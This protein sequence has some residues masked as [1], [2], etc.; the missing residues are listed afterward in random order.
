MI[1]RIRRTFSQNNAESGMSV[2][3]LLVTMIL[4]GMILLMAS[5]MYI[6]VV[7]TTDDSKS[8]N[9]GTRVAS[10]AMNELNRVV[11]FAVNSP[12]SGA[13]PLPA[14]SS[15]KASELVVYSLVDVDG[16]ASTAERPLKPVMVKIGLESDGNVFE[17]RWNPTASGQFWSF[18]GVSS[19]ANNTA[20]SSRVLGGKF[21]ATGT[22]TSLFRYFTDDCSVPNPPSMSIIDHLVQHCTE[23][24]PTGTSS[25]SLANRKEIST[26][27]VTMN[28]VPL[29]GPDD[30]PVII[31]NAIGMLNL[32]TMAGK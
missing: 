17:R 1:R 27:V 21:L 30:R 25:L 8:V 15:A 9:E 29:V 19:T 4:L 18:S 26:V 11:R 12:L 2:I 13:D 5:N 32:G 6:S 16:L 23:L 14:F 7:R 22:S 31:T 28:T 3:E 10:N 24:V 20:V